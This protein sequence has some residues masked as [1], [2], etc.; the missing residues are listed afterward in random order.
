VTLSS[1]TGL[2]FWLLALV[3]AAA[4]VAAAV[5][6]RRRAVHAQSS[7]EASSEHA[8]PTTNVLGRSWKP[9]QAG[10]AIGLLALPAYLSSAASGRNYPLGVTHGVLHAALLVTDAPV[11]HVVAPPPAAPSP[12]SPAKAPKKKV[13]WWLVLLV[14][15]LMAG[16]HIS[17]RL[18]GQARLLPKPPDQVLVA[19]LGGFLVGAGA[20]LATGCVIGNILS[21]W[22]LMSIG[23]LLFGVV[24]ILA[25]WGTTALYL[26]GLR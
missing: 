19:I 4:T 12:T 3:I 14:G 25:N 9:W 16:S 23:G 22:A 1:L 26:R 5:L 18:S 10:I 13:V 8:T 7:P 21:G 20:T 11:R 2:P 17:A 15:S 24:T 6:L